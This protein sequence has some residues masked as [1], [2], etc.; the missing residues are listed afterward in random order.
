[1]PAIF[2][3]LNKYTCVYMPQHPRALKGTGY[4]GYVY[5]HIIVAEHVMNRPLRLTEEIH[6]LDFDRSNNQLDNILVL[7]KS[8]HTKLHMWLRNGAPG[9][10]HSGSNRV[11]SGKS[12]EKTSIYCL[13]CAKL[14]S[15][16]QT[17][18]CSKQC[19]G[20]AESRRKVKR[21][22]CSQLKK[23]LAKLSWGAVGRKYGVSDN[24][25]RKWARSYGLL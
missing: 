15:R 6:H 17:K 13:G 20:R 10:K 18:F 19:A 9:W 21:P 12:K 2:R 4:E 1:M 14:L 3:K 8:Q 22:G 23:D 7:E 25:V 11:N 5:E 16:K 24:A